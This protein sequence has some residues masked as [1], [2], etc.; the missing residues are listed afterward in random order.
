[1]TTDITTL[2]GGAAYCQFLLEIAGENIGGAFEATARQRAEAFVLA[3]EI[4]RK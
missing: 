3:I 2:F 1:M 4:G